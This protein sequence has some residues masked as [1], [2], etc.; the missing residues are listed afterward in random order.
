MEFR[1]KDIPLNEFEKTRLNG[2]SVAE[3]LN[4]TGLTPEVENLIQI[5][6]QIP[7]TVG[8]DSSLRP[9]ILD[10]CGMTCVFCH[11][12]GTPVAN[13]YNGS[14][15]LP[16]PTYQGGRVSVFEESNGANFLPGLM[17]PG[18]EFEEALHLMAETIGST[19][20]Q[21]TD[22]EPKLHPNLTQIIE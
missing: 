7:V 1:P 2:F 3:R 14:L 13:A 8:I 6:R 9:K 20:L 10:A 22:G 18:R 19:G 15:L 17:Q 16:N 5:E 12:E 21:L 4:L 11:N